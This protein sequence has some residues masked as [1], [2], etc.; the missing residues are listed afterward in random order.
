MPGSTPED[1]SLVSEGM[2][3]IRP[4]GQMWSSN[5][6]KNFVARQKNWV[7]HLWICGIVHFW[8]TS[9]SEKHFVKGLHKIFVKIL[10]S[11][12]TALEQR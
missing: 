9:Q 8:I 5:M 4:A 11:I 7:M 10:M 3:N 2:H 6:Q 12:R 1:E